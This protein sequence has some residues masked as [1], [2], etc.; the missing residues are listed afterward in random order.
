[1]NEKK[2]LTNRKGGQVGSRTRWSKERGGPDAG[3]EPPDERSTEL[4]PYSPGPCT[5]LSPGGWP[6]IL[7]LPIFKKIPGSIWFSI[8]VILFLFLYIWVRAAFPRY[9]YDQ[10]MGLGR[11]VF[12][13]LSLARVVLVSGLSVTFQWLP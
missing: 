6:P 4:H 3:T 11:K 13:P 1:M 5:S 9:R 12:L 8:K 10:L 7:D 2:A